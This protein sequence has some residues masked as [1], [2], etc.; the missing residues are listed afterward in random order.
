MDLDVGYTHE[1]WPAEFVR[2]M[3]PR[4]L[5]TLETRLADRP[6]V[7]VQ[8]TDRQW[9]Q[10]DTPAATVDDPLVVRGPAPAVLCWLVGRPVPAT[11]GLDAGRHGR[12][13]PL[14]RLC[15]WA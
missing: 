13:R 11:V 6:T 7:H 9:A 12:S 15:P 8:V 2:L 3:L 1:D 4:V 5:P 10:A 14:P